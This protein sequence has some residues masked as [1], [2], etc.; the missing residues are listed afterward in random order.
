MGRRALAALLLAGAALAGPAAGALA[1][2]PVVDIRVARAI[3]D[4]PKIPARL[5]VTGP[6][7][8][9]RGRAG[10]ELRGHSSQMFPKKQYGIELR[11]RRGEGRDAALLGLPADDDWALVAN[12]S[13]KT[14]MRNA[15]AYRLARQ[16]F[17]RWAPR[18][19][20]VELRLN[21]RYRG[22]YVLTERIELHDERVAAGDGW[23]LE[24]VF[25]YQA[26]GERRL[27]SPLTG[28]PLLYT[29][30]DEPTRRE[31]EAD[32]PP[33]GPLRAR[34]VRP[35]SATGAGAGAP[36][37]TRA[38]PSTTCCSKSCSEIPTPSTPVPTS[39]EPPVAGS[40][41]DRCG[42]STSQWATP[43][44]TAS[45]RRRA[46][47]SGSGPTWSG[48]TATA[49]SCGQWPPA[50]ASCAATGCGAGCWA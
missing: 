33:G 36:T 26:L 44:S 7:S 43:R 18:T 2:P 10:I 31:A 16:V 40:C 42:T 8:R 5:R 48:S 45:A 30:P 3:P 15:I 32:P 46:G 13:D 24:L 12:Y 6:D 50:G 28:R 27:R 23:I 34:A 25:G 14:L 17:G 20:Y 38:R 9:Y 29:D 39:T 47:T 22:V 35:A 4:D 19:R 1:R 49:A 37:P 41:S 11:D 21:G